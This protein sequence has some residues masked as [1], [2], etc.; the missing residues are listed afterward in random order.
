MEIKRG[1]IYKVDLD[2]IRG[3][4]IQ[5]KRRAVIVS[6]DAINE[7]SSVVI[8]CPITDGFG[9]TSSIHV[10]IPAG[11][12]SLEKDSVAHC[13]QVRAVDKERLGDRVGKLNDFKSAKVGRGLKEALNLNF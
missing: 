13:G 5:K 10:E 8:T 12:G 11:E 4:E 6:T 9:K 3:S 7:S 1:E 2:P